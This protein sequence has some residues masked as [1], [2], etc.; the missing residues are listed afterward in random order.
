MKKLMKKLSD[1]FSLVAAGALECWAA[2]YQFADSD[3]G[4][5][6]AARPAHRGRQVLAPPTPVDG[7]EAAIA[8]AEA[9]LAADRRDIVRSS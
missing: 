2:D 7:A 8:Q 6:P 4:R 1:A 9:L 3:L 5:A